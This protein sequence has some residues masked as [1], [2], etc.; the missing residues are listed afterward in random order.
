MRLLL[1]DCLDLLQTIDDQSIDAVVTDPPYSLAF[2]G[3]KWDSHESPLHY[4][5]WCKEW[6]EHCLRVLKPGGHLVSFGG[7]RTY[8]RLTCGLEDAGFEIRDCLSWL[9][10]SG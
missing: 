8:H 7:T 9:Y 5:I 10:G 1:G 4:Q 3:S 2:M 6:G